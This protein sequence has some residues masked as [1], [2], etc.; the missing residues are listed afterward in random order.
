MS[1][2]GF[3]HT[4][5]LALC[6]VGADKGEDTSRMSAPRVKQCH[7]CCRCRR[8]CRR[9]CFPYH[10]AAL[11]HHAS[12]PTHPFHT[13]YTSLCPVN[14]CRSLWSLGS[15]TAARTSC[16][17]ASQVSLCCLSAC[18]FVLIVC[19]AA[20]TFLHSVITGVQRCTVAVWAVGQGVAA[21]ALGLTVLPPLILPAGEVLEACTFVGPTVLPRCCSH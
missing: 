3:A 2:I 15:A 18:L 6:F 4:C 16:T 14:S 7:A 13:L 9:R 10:C 8:H 11:G 20:G 21:G 17:R 5:F 1:T 19:Q 12:P